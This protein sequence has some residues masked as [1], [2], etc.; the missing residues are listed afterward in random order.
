M[1]KQRTEDTAMTSKSSFLRATA[2]SFCLAAGLSLAAPAQADYYEGLRAYDAG[3]FSRA[4]TEWEKSARAGDAKSMLRLGK[5]YETGKGV[6]RDYVKAL[7][8]Y[9]A[10]HKKGSADAGLAG[11]FLQQK[12]SPAQRAA[13][14]QQA[15]AILGGAS[16]SG[17]TAANTGQGG[18]PFNPA[19]AE[20]RRTVRDGSYTRDGLWRF[21]ADGTVKGVAI[22]TPG[23]V[24]LATQELN[25]TGKWR[26]DGNKLCIKWTKWEDG[27]E[28]CYTA[29]RQPNGRYSFTTAG[30]G[31]SFK[32][33]VAY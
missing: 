6:Q 18:L 26:V 32:A 12:M 7:A 20:I 29:V 28:V 30:T 13:A 21:A 9:R 22:L 2:L 14:D 1:L 17:S 27:Q 5:L 23:S 25:D 31:S 24:T 16:T 33:S 3:Q 8:W 19:G 4:A 11:H 15:R 10:G